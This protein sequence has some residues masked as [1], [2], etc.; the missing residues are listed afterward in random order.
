MKIEIESVWKILIKE[1][2]SWFEIAVKGVPNFVAAVFVMIIFVFLAK[3]TKNIVKKW[4][5]KVLD[6]ETVSNLLQTLSYMIVILVGLSISL[7]ILDLEKTV[8]SL[9]AG[10]GVIGLALGFAFQE[11][12]SN[13]VSGVFIAFR[14]PYQI[15]DIVEIDGFLGQVTEIS[16]RTSSIMTFQGLEVLMPNK[17]MFTK[18]FI[19]YTTTPRR[20]VDIEV[21]VSYGDNLRQVENVVKSALENIEGRIHSEPIEVYFKEFGDS[22]INFEARIWVEY[23]GNKNFLKARHEAVIAIKEKFD[24]NG[25]TIPFPIR[26]LDFGIK[27]GE[28]LQVPLKKVIKSEKS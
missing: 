6:N 19:N 15:G 5:P 12:A 2:E 16:L 13:F 17:H 28:N 14:H 11:I 10:A 7:G 26:T 9:L 21:G 24:E 20:R 8:T 25:I 18:P 23:P 27:G 22:S 1:I 4:S 3:F